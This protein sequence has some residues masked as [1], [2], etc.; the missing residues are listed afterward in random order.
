MSKIVLVAD[1]SKTIRTAIEM[2]YGKNSGYE[3]VSTS[4]GQNALM[5]A[6]EKKP[7][8]VLADNKL[9]GLDGYDL[10]A[11]MKQD[12]STSAIPVV[13]MTSQMKPFDKVRGVGADANIIKP[14]LTQELLDLTEKVI[15]TGAK[16]QS[17]EEFEIF[18]D[19]E[20]PDDVDQEEEFPLDFPEMG[21]KSDK[22]TTPV[23]PAFTPGS[24]PA[25]SRD[26]TSAPKPSVPMAP[27]TPAA[28]KPSIPVAPAAPAAPAAPKPSIPVAPAA[29][30]A[31]RP[32]IPVAPAAPAA[33]RPSIPVAPAAP[34]APRP[35]IP[36]APVAPAAPAAPRPSIPVAP[37][38]PAAPAAPRPSIP[39]APV[40]PAAPRP[41]I[42]VAPVAPAAPKPS[43]PVAP[44]AP[45][46]PKPS[47]P[48]APVAPAAPKPSIPVAPA[49]SSF[50]ARSVSSEIETDREDKTPVFP[51]GVPIPPVERKASSGQIPVV[52]SSNV[53][54]RKSPTGEVQSV[55]SEPAKPAGKPSAGHTVFLSSYAPPVA[56]EVSESKP[57]SEISSVTSA[58]TVN[59]IVAASVEK[60]QAAASE[61]PEYL[62]LTKLS[63]EIIE[64]IAW[65]VVPQ[66]AEVIIKEVLAKDKKLQ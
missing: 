9:P 30:A 3:V 24:I 55:P 36:V 51:A 44:V 28:P 56:P 1:D 7:A 38:A 29:P 43:I 13:I 21:F 6:K 4:D 42:P 33:P 32:S 11:A 34:A 17:P 62:A 2:T 63:R 25:V 50:N 18:I 61:S 16:A 22:P 66:L 53:L 8:L 27:S 40:A 19:A 5:L 54:K 10:L 60:V 26:V 23:M 45:A 49:A 12:S 31:P 57:A 48:V 59:R 35:S 47:I 46:A 58:E 15:S 20:P 41:S 14:F 52:S 64:K 39:V 37:V 65:E